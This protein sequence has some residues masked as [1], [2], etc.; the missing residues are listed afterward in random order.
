[1]VKTNLN[2]TLESTQQDRTEVRSVLIMGE[3]RAVFSLFMGKAQIGEETDSH[4]VPPHRAL[5][6]LYEINC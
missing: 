5:Q 6:L 3:R 4:L 2:V 1:M